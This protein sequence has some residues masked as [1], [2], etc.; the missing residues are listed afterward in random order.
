MSLSFSHRPP[1][2]CIYACMKNIFILEQNGYACFISQIVK[3]KQFSFTILKMLIEK[4]SLR[5]LNQNV[6][7]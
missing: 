7:E 2:N 5:S 6:C 3:K 4:I 1:L